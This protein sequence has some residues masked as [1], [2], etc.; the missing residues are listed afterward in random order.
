MIL[1]RVLRRQAEAAPG[2]LLLACVSGGADSVALFHCLLEL[3]PRMGFRL[4]VCH[5]HHGVRGE[6]AE[7]D[8]AFVQEMCERHGV[9]FHLKRLDFPQ[10]AKVS[11]NTLRQARYRAIRECIRETGA[12]AAILAHHRDDLAET[13][14]MR[15]IQGSGLR[16]LSGFSE[17]AEHE[18]I[19]LLRP[20]K[21]ITKSA[22]LEFLR[23]R[24]IS[25]REDRTNIDCS[26]LR[27]RI[28]HEL[29]PFLQKGFAPDISETLARTAEQFSRL[30][31]YITKEAECF[32]NKYVRM[33]GEGG[34]AVEYLPLGEAAPLPDFLLSE[35]LRLWS[36][37]ISGA[38]MPPGAEETEALV[39]LVREGRSGSLVRPGRGI[40]AYK[41]FEHIF[42]AG[43]E[44]PRRAPKSEILKRLAP[45]LIQ[46]QNEKFRLPI[47]DTPETRIE[48]SRDA[49]PFHSESASITISEGNVCG[50]EGRKLAITLDKV[51]FPL[52]LRTRRGGDEIIVGGMRKILKRWFVEKR[53]PSP[54][55]NH[56]II[57]QDQTGI[58]WAP[59]MD[60]PIIPPNEIRNA[61][62]IEFNNT[63]R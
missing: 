10:G 53:I 49:I 26:F 30:Y 15:L 39:R 37:R 33:A 36:A 62:V 38:T 47:F 27:N 63:E 46:V 4:A 59:G 41:D 44:V 29:V 56:A 7:A 13:F 48:V 14:L 43:M 21:N 42:M 54:L 32:L 52:I 60:I 50:F 55:R 23:E 16:G 45:L 57:V 3:A 19:I 40:I 2:S 24:G 11:E 58:L 22:I 20:M 12:R 28:R 51:A 5:V 34:C 1:E 25:W 35:A 18:G 8:A 31:A 61:L 17:R 9:A 6:E